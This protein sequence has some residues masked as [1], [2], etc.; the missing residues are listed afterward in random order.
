MYFFSAGT[1]ESSYNNLL[2]S[3]NYTHPL[4]YDEISSIESKMS[5]ELTVFA[6]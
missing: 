2:A 5:N 4:G 1:I 3:T 6:Y